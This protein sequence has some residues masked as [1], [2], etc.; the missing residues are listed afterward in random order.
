MDEKTQSQPDNFGVS[1]AEMD[2]GQ[3]KAPEDSDHVEATESKE[4]ADYYESAEFK[5]RERRVVRKLD[6]YIAPL[7]GSFNFIVCVTWI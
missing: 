6:F 4:I 3:T 2:L 5:A 1:P 7:L